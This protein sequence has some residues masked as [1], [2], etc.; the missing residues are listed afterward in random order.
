MLTLVVYLTLERLYT[1]EIN[2]IN[3]IVSCRR[4]RTSR[5]QI[6]VSFIETWISQVASSQRAN[7]RYT[8][9]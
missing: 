2:R 9:E 1:S 6:D 8:I 5:H 7:K 4:T 3:V